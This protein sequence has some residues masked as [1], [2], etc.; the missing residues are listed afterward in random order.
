MQVEQNEEDQ[1]SFVDMD[2]ADQL[3]NYPEETKLDDEED[4]VTVQ[5]TTSSSD[6]SNSNGY[7]EYLHHHFDQVTRNE[8]ASYKI[9]S[10]L[11]SAGAPLICY[12]RLVALLKKLT[13][14]DG[15]DVKKALNRKTL[16]QRLER[17]YKT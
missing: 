8:T 9:M 1:F 5:S 13:K 17:R 6:H 10:L 3:L 2:D 16:M 14:H 12:D 4:D 7:P 15:F 11:D